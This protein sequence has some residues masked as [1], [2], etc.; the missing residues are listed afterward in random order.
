MKGD[1]SGKHV[2]CVQIRRH[3]VPTY[4]QGL[5]IQASGMHVYDK[6]AMSAA[7]GRAPSW[8]AGVRMVVMGPT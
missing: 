7:E 2:V 5:N 8:V 1:V 3:G 4:A 6:G